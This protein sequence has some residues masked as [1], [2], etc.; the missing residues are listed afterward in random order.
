MHIFLF[1]FVFREVKE[2]TQLLYCNMAERKFNR[3]EKDK[4]SLSKKMNLE[5]SVKYKE[6]YE[7]K[8]TL[9]LFI[10]FFKSSYPKPNPPVY[11]VFQ[12]ISTPAPSQFV[13]TPC[14]FGT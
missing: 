10:Y 13:K 4:Y 7:K 14:L 1:V 3:R 8:H 2:S 6:E 5:N 12:K 11:S 9:S